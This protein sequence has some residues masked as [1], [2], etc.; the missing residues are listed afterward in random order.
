[1]IKKI[2]NTFFYFVKDQNND[3]QIK[4]GIGKRHIESLDEI[5]EKLNL[6]FNDQSL[7]KMVKE[8]QNKDYMVF[9]NFGIISGKSTYQLFLP[10]IMNENHI[11]FLVGLIDYKNEVDFLGIKGF[12]ENKTIYGKEFCDLVLEKKVFE[13]KQMSCFDI[14]EEIVESY[15]KNNIIGKKI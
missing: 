4:K 12:V 1:M 2:N 13:N 7:E 6:S 15:Y 11:K 8:A 10:K 9:W 5:K 14:I 3:I